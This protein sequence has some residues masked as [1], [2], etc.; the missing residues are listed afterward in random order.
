MS[1]IIFLLTFNPII[2]LARRLECPD[3]ENLPSEGS[4][5]YITWDEANSNEDSGW[6]RCVVTK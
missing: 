3:S 1:P 5:I 6:Y 4:T 2:Q